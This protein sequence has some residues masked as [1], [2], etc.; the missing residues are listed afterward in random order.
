M[1]LFELGTGD[2]L[3]T[4]EQDALLAQARGV[5]LEVVVP[6]STI[7]AEHVA[8]MVD[9]NVTAAERDAAEAFL[10]YLTTDAGREMLACGYLRCGPMAVTDPSASARFFRVEDLGVWP[11]A[12]RELVE[13]LWQEE[14]APG[15]DG[16]LPGDVG[17]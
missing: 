4:Y 14:I 3:V 6:G 7:V 12:Y 2:A 13:G 5:P 10:A 15:L 11:Q 1:T 16:T 17:D 8:V 9:G